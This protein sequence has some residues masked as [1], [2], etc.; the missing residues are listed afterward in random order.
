MNIA[1]SLSCRRLSRCVLPI[2][3]LLWLGAAAAGMSLLWD[4]ALT[5]GE[6][7]KSLSDWPVDSKLALDKVDPTL[8]VFV[9]PRCPCSRA[10]MRELAVA[11]GGAS[12]AG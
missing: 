9:H 7:G 2:L 11:R 1:M 10:S 6:D 5:P 3:T 12:T 8:L 4:Y